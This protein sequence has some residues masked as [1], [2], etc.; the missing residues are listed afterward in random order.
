MVS[1]AS[2]DLPGARQ[3]GE[4]DQPITRQVEIDILQVVGPGTP[5]ADI[6]HVTNYYTRRVKGG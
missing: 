5:D 6:L 1:K 4:Y 2:E 3:A